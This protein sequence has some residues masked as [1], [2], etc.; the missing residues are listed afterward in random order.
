MLLLLPLIALRLPHV[1]TALLRV[2]LTATFTQR[3][4]RDLLQFHTPPRLDADDAVTRAL[5][6]LATLQH[7]DSSSSSNR[8]SAD[9]ADAAQLQ[10]LLRQS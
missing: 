5:S 4:A 10:Q 9:D 3:S 1:A 8:T 7:D 6:R 2:P